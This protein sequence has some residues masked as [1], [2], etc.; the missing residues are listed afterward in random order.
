MRETVM[1][2]K[3]D[4]RIANSVESVSPKLL[5]SKADNEKIQITIGKN[6]ASIPEKNVQIIRVYS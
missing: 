3:P 4:S 6:E 2:S 5:I 1:S